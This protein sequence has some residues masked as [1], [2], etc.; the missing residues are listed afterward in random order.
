MTQAASLPDFGELTVPPRLEALYLLGDTLALFN[1]MGLLLLPGFFPDIIL[2]Q[3]TGLWV[4]LSVRHVVR[5]GFAPEKAASQF[6]E[7]TGEPLRAVL[8]G[9]A[10]KAY[11]LLELQ[12]PGFTQRLL[13]HLLSEPVPVIPQP[14]PQILDIAHIL[15]AYGCS[16]QASNKSPRLA[17][18]SPT[19][20]L[21]HQPN[22]TLVFSSV[23][24]FI[25]ELNLTPWLLHVAAADPAHEMAQLLGAVARHELRT[26]EWG[27]VIPRLL[28]THRR[29]EKLL[30]QLAKQ[31]L[32]ITVLLTL[33]TSLYEQLEKPEDRYA[34]LPV[35]KLLRR[36]LDKLPLDDSSARYEFVLACLID[37]LEYFAREADAQGNIPASLRFAQAG[38]IVLQLLLERAGPPLTEGW[39]SR[40]EAREQAYSWHKINPDQVLDYW[41]VW[42]FANY[43]SSAALAVKQ[44]SQALAKL[45]EQ[46]KIKNQ[47]W[48]AVWR[49]LNQLRKALRLCYALSQ[50]PPS[51]EA[52]ANDAQG[53][54]LMLQNLLAHQQQS[55][56]TLAAMIERSST[57]E[58]GPSPWIA[59]LLPTE[60]LPQEDQPL[61]QELVA[62]MAVHSVLASHG[63][64]PAAIQRLGEL[65]AKLP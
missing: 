35:F 34:E 25:A 15:R 50:Q 11:H 29:R 21:T 41:T 17:F 31:P 13:T 38:Q 65:I 32:P 49:V 20:P 33:L 45:F 39:F 7:F 36:S 14:R 46:G 54:V 27:G 28:G 52:V 3:R 58:R 62:C 47:L 12:Y 22:W 63:Y 60:G 24:V 51:A 16:L 1:S 53:Q 56:K 57:V 8:G 18:A 42:G 48:T 37:G 40:V 26:P 43:A 59:L 5:D 61:M 2:N 64:G 10:R 4:L 30:A 9:Y 55:L 19:V 23:A 6:E 44:H